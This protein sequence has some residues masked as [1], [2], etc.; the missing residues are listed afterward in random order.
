MG[1]ITKAPSGGRRV[2]EHVATPFRRRP[3][4]RLDTRDRGFKMHSVSLREPIRPVTPAGQH[5]PYVDKAA[6]SKE[7]PLSKRWTY[8]TAPSRK[9]SRNPAEHFDT[10][11]LMNYEYEDLTILARPLDAAIAQFD[12]IID[13]F[14]HADSGRFLA[15]QSPFDCANSTPKSS[16]SVHPNEAPTNEL[17]AKP[18]FKTKIR[19]WIRQEVSRLSTRR[20]DAEEPTE[21]PRPAKAKVQKDA[22]TMRPD[23]ERHALRLPGYQI[24]WDQVRTASEKRFRISVEDANKVSNDLTRVQTH[25]GVGLTVGL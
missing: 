21:T 19:Q 14:D 16:G 8:E 23:I 7:K 20:Q 10:N 2:A 12:N 15:A 6:G 18:S 3:T 9:T 4:P 17:P 25:K 22:F 11:A 5:S 1:N 13:L 24:D